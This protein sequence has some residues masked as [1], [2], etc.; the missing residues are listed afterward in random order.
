[1]LKSGPPGEDTYYD[2]LK[3]MV[4]L[5]YIV[6]FISEICDMFYCSKGADQSVAAD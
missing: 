5:V 4:Y 3:I 2:V 6:C 1:M